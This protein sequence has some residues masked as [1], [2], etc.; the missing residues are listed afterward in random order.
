[1]YRLHYAPDNASLIVRLVLEELGARY[2]TVLVDRSIQ[3]QN[4]AAYLALNPQGQ[5]PVLV[6]PDGPIF[7]TAAILL[8]LCERH[9]AMAPEAG[10]PAR[11]GFLKWLFFISNTFHADMRLLFYPEK[12]VGADE[13]MHPALL[14]MTQKRLGRH[15]GTLENLY[16]QGQSWLDPTSPSVLDYYIAACLRFLALYPPAHRA[17][18]DLAQFPNLHAHV[19]ELEVRPAVIAAQAAEGLGATPFSAPSYAC[20]PEGCAVG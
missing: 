3:A 14:V 13:S 19:R 16:L 6:T 11:G 10:T 20:P 2:D 4:S 15:L 7:E 9:G 5:I 18:F 8:W 1:M 17:W 12:Y